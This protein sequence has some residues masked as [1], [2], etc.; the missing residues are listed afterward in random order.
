MLTMTLQETDRYIT[1]DGI[2]C[3]GNARRLLDYLEQSIW[4]STEESSW[5]S[6]FRSKLADRD[7]LGQDDLFFIGSQINNI[8]ALFEDY[9]NQD[10]LNLLDQIEEECC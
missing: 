9:G 5:N 2:N 6:Y 7:A 8:R 4:Q 3:S 1:F 10:A